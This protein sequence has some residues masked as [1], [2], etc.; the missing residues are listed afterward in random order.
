GE[1][2]PELLSTAIA[3]VLIVL[4]TAAIVAEMIRRERFAHRIGVLTGAIVSFM[5]RLVRRPAVSAWGD[6]ALRF[7][8]RLIKVLRDRGL[9]LFTAEVVSQLSLYLVF[10]T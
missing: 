7:R 9:L 1:G 4:A 3:G 5:L 2:D 6:A 10:L 8:S